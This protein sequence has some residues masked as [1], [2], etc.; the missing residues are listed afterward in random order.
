MHDRQPG[1]AYNSSSAILTSF[2]QFL[3]LLKLSDVREILRPRREALH[4]NECFAADDGRFNAF[5]DFLPFSCRVF[6]GKMEWLINENVN[7]CSSMQIAPEPRSS[8]SAKS[9][10]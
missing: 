1:C 7:G 4:G 8:L 5:G 10:Y 2:P 3:D 6:F 9:L